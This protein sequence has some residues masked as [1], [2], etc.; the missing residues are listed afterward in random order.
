MKK[1][2][3]EGPQRSSEYFGVESGQILTASLGTDLVRVEAMK[4][5]NTNT[6]GKDAM[7]FK[8]PEV[9]KEKEI[10]RAASRNCD[11]EKIN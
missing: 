3:E 4:Y 6:A 7:A 2:R 8:R 1:L 9:A 10:G 5:P 11:T